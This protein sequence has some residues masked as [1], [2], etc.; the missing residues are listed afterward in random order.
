MLHCNEYLHTVRVACP[1]LSAPLNGQ[2][3]VNDI[4]DVEGSTATYSCDETYILVGGATRTC[5]N[6]G[7][8]EGVW[9]GSAPMCRRMF[10]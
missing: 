5:E 10:N 8:V 2:V 9:N 3:T 7:Q 1:D 4:N 6:T